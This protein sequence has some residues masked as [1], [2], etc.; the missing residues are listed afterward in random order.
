LKIDKSFVESSDEAAGGSSAF[1]KAIVDLAKSLGLTKVAVGVESD[2]QRDVLATI[3]CDLAQ[4][5]LMAAP[6]DADAASRLI[7]RKSGPL[8]NAILQ[9]AQ[10]TA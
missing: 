4:G 3:G 8:L 9:A 1:V 10:R 5:Y 7:A 6:L 2:H